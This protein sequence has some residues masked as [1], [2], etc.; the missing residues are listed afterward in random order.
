MAFGDGGNDMVLLKAA[1]M[2]VAMDNGM[3]EVKS[4]ADYVTLS[5]NE[6]GVA[7]AIEKFLL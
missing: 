4:I 2:G 6:D 5:N 3:P 7:Y 1:G